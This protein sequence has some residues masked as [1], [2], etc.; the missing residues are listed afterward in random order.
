MLEFSFL[1]QDSL[2]A[3]SV[4]NE[5]TL[6]PLWFSVP[7]A[8]IALKRTGWFQEPSRTIVPYLVALLLPLLSAFPSILTT[9]S[10]AFN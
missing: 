8:S 9:V 7:S 2:L 6:G 10:M 5:H 1:F 3:Y 4:L